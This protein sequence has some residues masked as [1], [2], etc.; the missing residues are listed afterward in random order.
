MPT[1]RKW[2]SHVKGSVT[3]RPPRLVSAPTCSC[4]PQ[5][6]AEP[7]PVIWGIRGAHAT[8]ASSGCYVVSSLPSFPPR[9]PPDDVLS[10]HGPP[11]LPHS[12]PEPT[13]GI[14]PTTFRAFSS[15]MGAGPHSARAMLS[16][17]ICLDVRGPLPY[18]VSHIPSSGS[19]DD[20]SAP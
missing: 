11:E 10:M 6:P 17:C 7:C 15:E 13:A 3:T 1:S 14:Q 8:C 4:R 16:C 2:N 20:V 18:S 12:V 19:D 5:P 9:G